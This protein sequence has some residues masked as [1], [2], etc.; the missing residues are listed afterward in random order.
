MDISRVMSAGAYA[1]HTLE[2]FKVECL[3]PTHRLVLGMRYGSDFYM[4]QCSKA[5]R[6]TDQRMRSRD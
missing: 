3:L 4:P 6:H 1:A 2:R 5:L